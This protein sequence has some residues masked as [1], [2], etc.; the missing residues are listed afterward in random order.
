MYLSL[1]YPLCSSVG[2]WLWVSEIALLLIWHTGLLEKL[3][4]SRNTDAREA[5]K[6]PKCHHGSRNSGWRIQVSPQSS[7]SELH[8]SLYVVG[9]LWRCSPHT[10]GSGRKTV[11]PNYIFCKV[12]MLEWFRWSFWWIFFLSQKNISASGSESYLPN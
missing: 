2:S 12:L 11:R 10:Q 7:G 1:L 4:L 8:L 9:F 6:T 3:S 5:N